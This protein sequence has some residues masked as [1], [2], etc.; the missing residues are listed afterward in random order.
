M[1]CCTQQ[2]DP[3]TQG[4]PPGLTAIPATALSVKATEEIVTGVPLTI[5]VPHAGALLSSPDTQDFSACRLTSRD[6]ILVTVPLTMTL[7]G[8]RILN[9]LTP[10]LSIKDKI[11]HSGLTL[12]DHLLTP[13]TIHRKLL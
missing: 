7:S 8:S 5:P 10:L 4:Y 2:L 6:I 13:M 11:A 1:G 12:T 3:V 9:P